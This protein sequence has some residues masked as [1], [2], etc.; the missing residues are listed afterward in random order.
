M[1]YPGYLLNPGDLFQVDVE[2]VMT[3][4]G[5]KRPISDENYEKRQ[6]EGKTGKKRG[7]KKAAVQAETEEHPQEEEQAAELSAQGEGEAEAEAS[8]EL[9]EEAAKKKEVAA[10]KQLQEHAKDIIKFKGDEMSGRRKRAIRALIKDARS[11]MSRAPRAGTPLEETEDIVDS[12]TEQLSKL[13]LTQARMT[14][15]S[16]EETP[17]AEAE[18]EEPSEDGAGLLSQRDREII[19][20]ELRKELENPKDP[21]KPYLTPWKPRRY[22]APFVFIPRYLEVNQNICAAVY[23]R[24]PVARQGQAEVP[25][26]FPQN[27]SSLAF[28]WY[29]RRG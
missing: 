1:T 12:L 8:V 6:K 20:L 7:G 15:Q 14:A 5:R 3:A 10:L 13:E 11:A 26:P 9:S 29:L 16:E 25:T 23:L 21:S 17:E 18:A 27:Y 24:H 22:M 19:K 28:N 2:R 4:T